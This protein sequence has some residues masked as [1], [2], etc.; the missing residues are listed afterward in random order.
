MVQRL[1]GR[2]DGKVSLA[3]MCLVLTIEYLGAI[4]LRH[5]R[6]MRAIVTHVADQDSA[7]NSLKQNARVRRSF[8]RSSN[9]GKE[10]N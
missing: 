10:S 9:P 8:T 1:D 2:A 6:E 7:R 4:H 3:E 5:A